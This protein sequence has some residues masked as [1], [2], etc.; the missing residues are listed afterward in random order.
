MKYYSISFF[1]LFIVF[2]FGM[3]KVNAQD[4]VI[5]QNKYTQRAITPDEALQKLKDGNERF[6][7]GKQIERDFNEQV[8]ETAKNQYPF[9]VLLSCIDSRAPAEIL[10]DLGIGDIF[11]IRIA[12]NIADADILGSMEFACKVSGSKL[13]LVLGHTNCGAIKGAIDDVQLGNLTGLL[14]KIKPAVEGTSTDGERSSKNKKFVDNVSKQNVL[15]AM[16]KVHEESPILD[17]MI[18]KGEVKLEGGMYDLK[19]GKV[20]FYD[21]K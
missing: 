5:T 17:D 6:V 19:T 14:S 3:V 4:T 8:K 18:K 11:N 9:A 21:D 10:F 12:G 20:E 2:L 1:I 7:Q 13:I 15:D 16:K